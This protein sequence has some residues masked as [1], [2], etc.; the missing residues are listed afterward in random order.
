MSVDGL[1]LS[2]DDVVVWGSG[3][4]GHHRADE[5]SQWGGLSLP[6]EDLAT[7]GEAL[8]GRRIASPLA[9][10]RIRPSAALLSRLLSLHEAA[11]HLARTAPDILARTEAGRAMERALIE[12]MVACF[13]SGEPADERSAHR[14]HAR[15]MRRL[16]EVLRANPDG[17]LY[18]DDLCRATDVSY[19]TL[20]GCCAEHLGMSPKR[21]LLL[22]RMHLARQALRRGEA[23]TAT[24]TEI[25]TND[26]FWELG[27][28]AVVYRSLFG[29]SPSTTLRRP[30]EEP[31]RSE[32][33]AARG[34]FA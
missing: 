28:F 7:A 14:H 31:A 27:R 19:R 29:E 34:K 10:H 16:E 24:V 17:P 20:Y 18:M 3:Q 5:A 13:V 6:S 22:R 21:Y 2:H 11:G 8:V 26:G 33:I 1:T 9:T 12:A 15:V 30:P 32:N 23:A 25:A 4:V